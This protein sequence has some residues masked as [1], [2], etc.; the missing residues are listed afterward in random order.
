MSKQKIGI[1][2]YGC[3]WM[4][5]VHA[6]AF[7]TLNYMNPDQNSYETVLMQVCTSGLKSS[8]KA[9]QRYGFKA[10]TDQV[11]EIIGDPNVRIFDNV[12]PDC[13]HVEASVQ[14]LK[15]GKHVICEKPLALGRKDALRMRNVARTSCAK[16][17]TCFNYRFFPA[18]RLAYELIKEGVIGK[19]Y[20][21]AGKYY[22]DQG[23]SE[24]ASV[25]DIWYINWS[26]IGQG[27]ATHMIDMSRF[28]VGEVSSVSG[29]TKTY[30][31]TRKSQN[32]QIKVCADEGFFGM[33]EFDNGATGVYESLGVAN[34]KRNEFSWQIYGSKGSLMWDVSHPNDL[35]VYLEDTTDS[36]VKGFSNVCVTDV[37]HP[38]MDI[39]WPAGHGIGWEHGHINMIKH[40]VDCIIDD[41]PV[42]PLGATFE[43]GYKT[44]VLIDALKESAACGKKVAIVYDD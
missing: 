9:F 29:M 21:F 32:D 39:W 38:F 40:F 15:A 23:A 26:G 25:E 4:G 7:H 31:V 27:I 44:A 35:Q 28:L 34:G 12:T 37:S 33:V 1:G 20:H 3:G 42:E 14:A 16:H 2:M 17:M 5:K 41:R 10:F 11:D 24:E 19:L 30:N 22:Q 6:N 8:K 43:D 36:R 13:Y 18:V